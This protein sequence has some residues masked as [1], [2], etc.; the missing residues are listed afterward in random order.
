M[1]EIAAFLKHSWAFRTCLKLEK[2]Q[3]VPGITSLDNSK[4]CND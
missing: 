1:M 3:R 2:G 4:G